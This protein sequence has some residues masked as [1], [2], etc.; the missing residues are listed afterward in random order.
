MT[1]LWGGG[2]IALVAV[3]LTA[4]ATGVLAFVA[5]TT[6]SQEPVAGA[7][8]PQKWLEFDV[9]AASSTF[10]GFLVGYFVPGEKTPAF[11]FEVTREQVQTSNARSVRIPLVIGQLKPGQT[12]EV[13]LRTIAGR[14]R[15][16]WSVPSATFVAPE[17]VPAQQAIGKAVATDDASR[18]SPSRGAEPPR[19]TASAELAA[20]PDL[21]QRLK[22]AFPQI[23]PATTCAGFRSARDCGSAL[24]AA[25]NLKVAFED[26]KRIMTEGRGR[27]LQRAISELK[28]DVNARA[29]ARKAGDQGR[30]LTRGGTGRK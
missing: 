19:R 18:N 14:L 9:P 4:G 17:A 25:A 23:D 16:G 3:V 21:V 27:N 15:S 30:K 29:E 6:Q 20:N 5:R 26:I 11:A 28:P 8:A 7:V 13:R 1:R 24:Y 12:Y 10:T 22:T 2:R